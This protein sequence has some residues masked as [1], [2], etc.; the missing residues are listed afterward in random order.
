MTNLFFG[1]TSV[2]LDRSGAKPPHLLD[3]SHAYGRSWQ[4]SAALLPLF[5]AAAVLQGWGLLQAS[6]AAICGALLAEAL[7][8][9]LKQ[10]KPVYHDGESFFYGLFCSL[11]LPSTLPVLVFFLAG[12]LSV[13]WGREIFGGF[14]QAVIFPPAVAILFLFLGVPS[15]MQAFD[16]KFARALS[17]PGFSFTDSAGDFLRLLFYP[18][19]AAPEDASFLAV[20][21]GALML[22]LWRIVRWE[23]AGLFFLTYAAVRI[24]I[25]EE[26]PLFFLSGGLWLCVF[27]ALSQSSA[28]PLAPMPRL[29]YVFLSAILAACCPLPGQALRVLA[30]FAAASLAAPW[31]EACFRG[32][33]ESE[34]AQR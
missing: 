12:F 17:A 30:G 16:F 15:L 20:L 8:R 3:R 32:Q 31:L 24:F 9:L 2:H 33:A 26:A 18:A 13:L 7:G 34:G 14:G 27:G 4:R 19:S 23:W 6:G 29:A 22:L 25:F 21:A 11:V 28:M 5:I 10:E 1:R